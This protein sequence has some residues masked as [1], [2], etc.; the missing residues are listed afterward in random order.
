METKQTERAAAP[1]EIAS[2]PADS[3]DAVRCVEAYF[4]ELDARFERGFDP[5]AGGYARDAPKDEGKGC[6]LIARIDGRAVGCGALRA[7]DAETGEI[8]RMWIAPEARGMGLARRLLDML[9]EA[10][11][12]FGMK[13]VRLDTNRALGEAQ[14]LYRK[15]GYREIAR[16]NDNL[17]A[18]FFFEKQ[19][20]QPGK[21]SPISR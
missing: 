17:Y 5:G 18:D 15:A 9:E 13:R 21:S 19:L 1:V 3:E 7:L 10:A 20:V 4:R 8:K 11:R 12:G 2:E 14:A 6:F 16:Y